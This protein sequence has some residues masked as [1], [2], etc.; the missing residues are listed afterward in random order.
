M[1]DVYLNG[2]AIVPFVIFEVAIYNWIGSLQIECIHTP[3]PKR[4]LWIFYTDLR[5]GAIPSVY[6]LLSGLNTHGGFFVLLLNSQIRY[7]REPLLT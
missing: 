7:K 3:L 5:L 2:V 6:L 4:I 1:S